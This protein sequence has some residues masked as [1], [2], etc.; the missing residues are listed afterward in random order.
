MLADS[1][2]SVADHW[3]LR[4][5]IGVISFLNRV[6]HSLFTEEEETEFQE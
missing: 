2:I 6:M 1:L 4:V 5:Q 3:N